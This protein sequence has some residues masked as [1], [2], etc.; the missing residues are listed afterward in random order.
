M[1]S[2][3]ARHQATSPS[4]LRR[5]SGVRAVRMRRPMAVVR[6]A[7]LTWGPRRP[8]GHGL[9]RGRQDACLRPSTAKTDPAQLAPTRAA[10]DAPTPLCTQYGIER[11][12]CAGR[13]VAP[14]CPARLP[15]AA[16]STGATPGHASAGDV[17][18]LRELPQKKARPGAGLH[19]IAHRGSAPGPDRS[20]R[21]TVHRRVVRRVLPPPTAR[22]VVDTPPG[23][24]TKDSRLA[25]G[26]RRMCAPHPPAVSA[27]HATRQ[28]SKRTPTL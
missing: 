12:R 15:A 3:S 7:T 17:P 4:S 24:G 5:R 13:S 9:E 28:K 27:W 19:R 22:P 16:R 25:P 11:M 6:L 26:A 2:P 21:Q 18:P 1:P 20:S 8:G 23:A 14:A 10:R